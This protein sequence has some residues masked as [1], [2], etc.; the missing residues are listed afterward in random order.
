MGLRTLHHSLPARSIWAI[1]STANPRTS[2]SIAKSPI[3]RS[4]TLHLCHFTRSFQPSGMCT[5]I[6]F[7]LSTDHSLW[8]VLASTNPGTIW[9]D[10]GWCLFR[11]GQSIVRI[12]STS[13][14]IS[15][16]VIA[17][18]LT[19]LDS[20][21][22]NVINFEQHGDYIGPAR[23]SPQA[24]RIR[25]VTGAKSRY[26][27]YTA[28]RK[29]ALCISSIFVKDSHVLAPPDKGLVQ[30]SVTGIFHSQEWERTVGFMG[31]V[32]GHKVLRAQVSMDAMQFTTRAHFGNKG[33]YC[34]SR[35]RFSCVISV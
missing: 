20:S 7:G 14:S 2:R 15:Q 3:L 21:C 1:S 13:T 12:C 31:T 11:S 33:V 32:F 16:P 8:S 26:Y 35:R 34:S 9:M 29:P 4:R 25:T 22:L 6:R 27:L 18:F 10:L 24:V 19:T 30:K 17:A 28:E 23:I 5:V